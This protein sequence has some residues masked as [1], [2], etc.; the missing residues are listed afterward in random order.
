MGGPRPIQPRAPWPLY[1]LGE[2]G[3]GQITI[4]YAANGRQPE[5]E[6]YYDKA[7]G[8]ERIFKRAPLGGQYAMFARK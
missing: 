3:Y 2:K 1:I 7:G 6:M 5:K 4:H 8:L